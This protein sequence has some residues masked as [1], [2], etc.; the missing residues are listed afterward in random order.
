MRMRAGSVPFS[1]KWAVRCAN[2]LVLPVPAPANM[3]IGPALTPLSGTAVPNVAAR[4]CDGFSESNA[5]GL[6]FIIRKLYR[7]CTYIQIAMQWL[8]NAHRIVHCGT[9][10][11]GGRSQAPESGMIRT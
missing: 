9:R 4:R 6:A 7:H 11:R 1:T 5:D 10:P 3:S 2:V 8:E